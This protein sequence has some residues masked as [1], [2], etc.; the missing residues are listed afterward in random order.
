MPTSIA[1]SNVNSNWVWDEA[2]GTW[3]VLE[4]STDSQV[5][6]TVTTTL[7]AVYTAPALKT[8]WSI[9]TVRIDNWEAYAEGITVVLEE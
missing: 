2:T 1:I 8:E 3:W 6:P 5:T 4:D 7:G 9:G